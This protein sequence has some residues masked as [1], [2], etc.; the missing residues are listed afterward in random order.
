MCLSSVAGYRPFTKPTPVPRKST[1]RYNSMFNF[2][3]VSFYFLL[4]LGLG[5]GLGS[6]IGLGFRVRDR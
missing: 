2:I 1:L 5:L 6:V 3:P 4:F